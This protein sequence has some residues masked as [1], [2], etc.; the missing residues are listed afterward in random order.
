MT[1]ALYEPSTYQAEALT[2]AARQTNPWATGICGSIQDL[3]DTFHQVIGEAG[4]DW[5]HCEFTLETLRQVNAHLRTAYN[6][7]NDRWARGYSAG[8]N[9]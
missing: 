7:V 4:P 3:R 6:Q 2:W 9:N 5:Q 1:V 8:D